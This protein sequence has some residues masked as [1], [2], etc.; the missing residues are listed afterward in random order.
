MSHLIEKGLILCLFIEEKIKDGSLIGLVKR[1][2]KCEVVGIELGGCYFRKG[3]SP[4]K[5]VVFNFD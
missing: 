2:F 4:R 5:R 1:L 3:F